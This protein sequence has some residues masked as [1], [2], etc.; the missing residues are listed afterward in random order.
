MMST[1]SIDR[2][3]S[4]ERCKM[5]HFFFTMI[6]VLGISVMAQQPGS[7]NKVLEVRLLSAT[8]KLIPGGENRIAVELTIHEP[9][10]INGHEPLSEFLI[11]TEISF[12]AAGG[13]V[14]DKIGY[15]PAEERIFSFSEEPVLVYEGI[16]YI[17]AQVS[18]GEALAG[19][20]VQISGIVGYQACNDEICLPPADYKFSWEIEVAQPGEEVKRVNTA[21]FGGAED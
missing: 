10:H 16:A 3:N 11:P 14:F 4:I 6:F 12:K 1:M 15:P 20:T 7:D 13:L 21:V 8:E 9:W 2:I 19:Q 17:T 18:A 5:K